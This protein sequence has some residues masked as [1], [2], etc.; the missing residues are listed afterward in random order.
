[1][2][3][4]LLTQPI[5]CSDIINEVYPFMEPEYLM[6]Y[7][8]ECANKYIQEINKLPESLFTISKRE[9]LAKLVLNAIYKN[10]YKLIN[11]FKNTFAKTNEVSE[12]I[13]R[14]ASKREEYEKG[15]KEWNNYDERI[16]LWKNCQ[17]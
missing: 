16:C 5:C 13:V 8:D 3:G 7:M 14:L 2:A 11:E 12:D 15:T 17:K 4:K 6:D 9:D 10:V 1:M